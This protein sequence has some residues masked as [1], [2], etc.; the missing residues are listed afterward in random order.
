MAKA[1]T[2]TVKVGNTTI[3]GATD[4]DKQN[5]AL[6]K[7]AASLDKATARG[8]SADIAKFRDSPVKRG[9]QAPEAKSTPKQQSEAAEKLFKDA[10]QAALLGLPKDMTVEQRENQVRKAAF[11]Y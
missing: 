10:D 2:S 6:G 7:K 9:D 8:S 4:A 3:K 1:K 5:I 11:G